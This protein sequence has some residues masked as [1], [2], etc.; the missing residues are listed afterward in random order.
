MRNMEN[1]NL[2]ELKAQVINEGWEASRK[3]EVVGRLLANED[4]QKIMDSF[5]G[6][7][8]AFSQ[9]LDTLDCSDGR[10][11]MG[12]KL[13]IAGSGLLLSEQELDGL[14]E[15]LKGKVK[16]VTTHRDCG[17]AAKKYS[18]LNSEEIP[19]GVVNSDDY[20]T[21]RGQQLAKRLGATH[22][23]LEMEEMANEY[24]NEVAIVLDQTGKFNSTNLESFP[25][26]FVCSGAGVGLN[27]SYMKSELETL[28]GI[29]LG[30]HGYGDRFSSQNPFYIIVSADNDSDRLIWEGVAQEV[31]SKFEEKVAV[32]T[33]L[34]PNFE[35]T[36]N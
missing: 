24:H 36:S 27:E 13:G 26:H 34:S 5:S 11:L 7:K 31:A 28:I 25:P 16:V 33:F 22:V 14:V 8:E 20:G 12:N 3:N 10:V 21:L 17:A 30:H 6:F 23:F 2:V 29:A 15:N 19:E 35:N 9:E 32:K 1:P 4:L 18:S